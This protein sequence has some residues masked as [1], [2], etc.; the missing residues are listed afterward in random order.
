MS[1]GAARVYVG[2]SPVALTGIF[3]LDENYR[4]RPSILSVRR[5]YLASSLK[6]IRLP[7]VG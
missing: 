4:R 6:I 5:L 3:P 1:A 2:M 7:V